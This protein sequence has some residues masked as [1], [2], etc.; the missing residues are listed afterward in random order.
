M[1]CATNVGKRVRLF[2]W[3]HHIR[4]QKNLTFLEIRDG[5]GFVQV[6]KRRVVFILKKVVYFIWQETGK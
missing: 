6:I 4:S 2:G 1:D 5:F 3:V